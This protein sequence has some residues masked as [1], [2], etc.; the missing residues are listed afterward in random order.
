MLVSSCGMFM[1]DTGEKI[2]FEIEVYTT[3]KN[4]VQTT[5]V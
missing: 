1:H 2:V 3:I 4:T 5:I